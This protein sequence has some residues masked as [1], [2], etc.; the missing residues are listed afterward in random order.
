M[1]ESAFS[2][3]DPG[4]LV[5]GD[6]SLRLFRRT[7]AERAKDWVAAYEFSMHA[8]GTDGR[9]GGVIFRAQPH[10]AL[11]LYRGHIGYGVNPEHRGNH[12]AERAVRLLGPFMRRHGFEEI[13]ITCNP[14]NWASR[15]TCERLGANFVE[16]VPLPETEEMYRRGEREKCRYRLSLAGG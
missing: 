12:Y 2:F 11:N 5:E 14:D 16:I 4:V 1:A 8:A 3:L 7:A 10:P 15:R 6:L 13:W 9:V